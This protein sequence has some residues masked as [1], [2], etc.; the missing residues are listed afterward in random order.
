MVP[1]EVD[2]GQQ[3]VLRLKEVAS[4]GAGHVT[5]LA[6]VVA[7]LPSLGSDRRRRGGSGDGLLAF[8]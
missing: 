2:K 6:I 4:M 8:C 5:S 3:V 1:L 7:Q